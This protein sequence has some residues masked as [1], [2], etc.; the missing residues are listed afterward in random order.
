V[1]AEVGEVHWTTRIEAPPQPIRLLAATDACV[2][3]VQVYGTG[4]CD[5]SAPAVRNYSR[6]GVA[7]LL[8]PL[9]RIC[10]GYSGLSG[11]VLLVHRLVVLTWGAPRTSPSADIHWYRCIVKTIWGIGR[12]VSP[13]GWARASSLLLLSPTLFLLEVLP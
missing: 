8:L 11:M 7:V 3:C 2:R 4:S 10:L 6:R 5:G 1:A 9:M 12:V 13:G